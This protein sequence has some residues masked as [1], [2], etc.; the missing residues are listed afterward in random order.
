MLGTLNAVLPRNVIARFRRD[1]QGVA[2]VELA[3]MLPL[4]LVLVLGTWEIGRALLL[5][6]R[7]GAS[8]AQL[9]GLVT[10]EATLTRATLQDLFAAAP[11]LTGGTDLG[12]HG[13]MVV[14]AV[15]GDDQGRGRVA[16][17][18]YG[19]GSLKTG[20]RVGKPGAYAKLP[21]GMT[22]TADETLI[23]VEVFFNDASSMNMLLGQRSVYRATVQRGRAGDLATLG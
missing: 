10:R 5:Q 13:V 19:A 2:A 11:V 1:R 6:M 21:D 9:G 4:M 12:A 17:Q 3:I 22:I 18:E 20:S 7:I 8:A 16:W 23:V 15:T 14:T